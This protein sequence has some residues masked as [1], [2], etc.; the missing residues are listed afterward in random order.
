MAILPKEIH[1]CNAMPI[2]IATQ[3]FIE[4]ERAICKFIW[5][6]KKNPGW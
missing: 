1:R 6:N 5:N 2:K 4:I 3:F